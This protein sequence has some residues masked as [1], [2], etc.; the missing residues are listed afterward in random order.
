MPTMRVMSFNIGCAIGTEDHGEN[1]W[2]HRAPLNV[3]TILHHAPDLIGFQE[4]DDGNL[5]SYHE[6]LSE[7]EYMLGPPADAPD[8]PVYNAIA[9]HPR[10]L[11]LLDS[12]G[13]Y[14]SKTPEKWSRDWDA[15]I[16]SVSPDHPPRGPQPP[17]G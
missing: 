5:Q 2:V 8:L 6:H 10:R 9:W 7:Y 4:C 14:L 16:S 12:G 13:F 17:C 15:V 1:A 3:T 11:E